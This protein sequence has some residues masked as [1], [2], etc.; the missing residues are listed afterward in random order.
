MNRTEAR[1]I[2]GNQPNRKLTHQHLEVALA[3]AKGA[4][5]VRDIAKATGFSVAKARRLL[6]SVVGRPVRYQGVIGHIST[7]TR[8]RNDR[9]K[10]GP[11]AALGGSRKIFYTAARWSPGFP[12]TT[13]TRPAGSAGP[14]TTR[15]GS[16]C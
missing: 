4:V 15:P 13:K 11:F 6:A 8:H 3:V 9:I 2:I 14:P 5:T 1:A 12:A 10:N 16:A 7:T